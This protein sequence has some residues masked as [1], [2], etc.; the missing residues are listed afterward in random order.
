VTIG[1]GKVKV[2]GSLASEKVRVDGGKEWV[3]LVAMPSLQKPRILPSLQKPRILEPELV[4]ERV[5]L[6]L[7]H[8]RDAAAIADY[9]RRNRAFHQATDPI[10][11]DECYTVLYWKKAIRSIRRE[12]Q[13]DSSVRMML[14]RK[15]DPKRVIGVVNFNQIVRGVFQACYLGYAIDEQE[16]GKG[17]M[18]EALR[19]A[20]EYMFKERKLHR[21]MA[22]YLP[23][24]ERSGKLLEK[25][26]FVIEGRAKEYLK[27]NGR[28]QDHI[29][30]SLTN[31]EWE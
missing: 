28:W 24:N 19:L 25:L 27:I 5:V 14:F 21:I 9:L 26:G 2:D 17:L 15:D 20:I 8:A 23:E 12:F 6:C 16:E 7:P 3:Y 4:G 11:P 22:N 29:L 31:R 13:L 30:T 18:S 1:A 10:R